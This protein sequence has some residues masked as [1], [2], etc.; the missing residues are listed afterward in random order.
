MIKFMQCIRRKPQ[1]SAAEFRKAWDRY[2]MAWQELARLSEARRMVTSIG[3][4]IDQNTAIRLA[5]GTGTP[6]DGVLEIWWADGAQVKDYAE[7]PGLQEKLSAMRALQEE[8]ADLGNSSF[9]FASE[10]EHLGSG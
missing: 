5:R 10:V 7:H 8:F 2:T 9:F 4:E 6:F 3:L 1:L